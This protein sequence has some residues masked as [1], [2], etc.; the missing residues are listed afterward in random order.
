M[1]KYVLVFLLLFISVNGHAGDYVIELFSENYHEKMIPGNGN[2]KIS[3]TWQVKSIYGNKVLILTGR[4]S[5]FRKW[6]R[7]DSEKY[8]LWVVK[9]PDEGDE[10]FK[11]SIS[12]YIDINQLQPVTDKE[13]RCEECRGGPPPVKPP[14]P[15][16]KPENQM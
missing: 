11:Y 7:N 8:K 12:V 13:W 6:L 2:L 9:I 4:D 1:K 14:A 16:P 10:K 5:S 3:H 15:L